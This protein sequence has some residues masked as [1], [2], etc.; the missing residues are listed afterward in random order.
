MAILFYVNG[1]SLPSKM[2][3]DALA[4]CGFCSLAPAVVVNASSL[5][6]AFKGI[7]VGCWVLAGSV[8]Q[9]LPGKHTFWCAQEGSFKGQILQENSNVNYRFTLEFS[10]E[11]IQQVNLVSLHY[12]LSLSLSRCVCVPAHPPI[13]GW[14]LVFGINS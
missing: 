7:G 13:S 1:S 11:N 6:G 5:A 14:F 3:S 12:V 8:C 9:S 2:L 4:G 10:L